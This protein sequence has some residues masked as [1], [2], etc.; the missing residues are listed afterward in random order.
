VENN[1]VVKNVDVFKGLYCYEK[2][3]VSTRVLV[4]LQIIPDQ[5]CSPMW[6]YWGENIFNGSGVI[7]RSR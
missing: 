1:S 4:E 2:D 5:E 6:N 3:K 7:T